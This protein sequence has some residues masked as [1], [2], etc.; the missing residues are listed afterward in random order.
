MMPELVEVNRLLKEAKEQLQGGGIAAIF[1]PLPPGYLQVVG[2][3]ASLAVVVAQ[4]AAAEK[5]RR[6]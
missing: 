5:A 1:N 4:L 6:G 2:A 3:V